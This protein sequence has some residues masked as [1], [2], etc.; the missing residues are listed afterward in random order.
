MGNDIIPQE[1][2]LF[3]AYNKRTDVRTSGPNAGT[4]ITRY[5][6]NLELVTLPSGTQQVKRYFGGVAMIVSQSGAIT[7]YYLFTD[8]LGSI[9][10]ITSASGS[11]IEAMSFDA[12]GARRDAADWQGPPAT[13]PTTTTHGFVGLEHVDDFG[14]VHMNGRIYDSELGRFVQADSQIEQDATQGLN[15]YTYVLNNP[16]SYT[17][18]SGHSIGGFFKKY[19]RAI[20]AIAIT[21]FAP[22]LLPMIGVTGF[23]AAVATGFV[24]GCVATGSLQGGLYGAFSAGLFYGIGTAFSQSNASWAYTNGELNAGGLAAKTLAHGVAGGVMSSLQG[25]TFGHGFVSAGVTQAFSGKIDGIDKYN[26]GFSAQRTFAAAMLGGSVTAATGGKF[27]NG[28]LTAAFSRAFN[29][30]MGHK[31]YQARLKELQAKYPMISSGVVDAAYDWL[32]GVNP[33]S[34]DP[35]GSGKQSEYTS[36]LLDRN[37]GAGVVDTGTTRGVAGHS[38]WI[39]PATDNSSVVGLPHTHGYGGEWYYQ[40]FSSDDVNAATILG[41]PVPVFLSNSNGDFSAFYPGMPVG[42]RIPNS[43]MRLPTGSAQGFL[44]CHACVP[45]RQPK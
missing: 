2:T 8:H 13:L 19:W 33:D 30:E 3:P 18:P 15:R 10:R 28:A 35:S 24:A 36:V 5:V 29:D 42:G 45:V 39:I 23:W 17:D 20:A 38:P 40:Y 43:M 12:H 22:Y 7:P 37:D 41:R 21:I 31:A 14:L 26:E 34:A 6:G 32:S 44:L 4:T 16:L 11:V 1:R 9:E 25:D 27:A